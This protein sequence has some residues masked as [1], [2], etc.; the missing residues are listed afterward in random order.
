MGPASTDQKIAA[1]KMSEAVE[2]HFK[3]IGKKEEGIKPPQSSLFQKVFFI[4][5]VLLLLLLTFA[6]VPILLIFSAH[7]HWC[8]L[9]HLNYLFVRSSK[10]QSI[11]QVKF[12]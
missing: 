7:P 12:F 11:S 4:F 9:F 6:V 5:T 8:S 10:N 2:V 1:A 3:F